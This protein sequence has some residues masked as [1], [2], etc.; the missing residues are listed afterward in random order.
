MVIS[1]EPVGLLEQFEDALPDHNV[2][3]VPAGEPCPPLEDCI[4]RLREFIAH[5]FDHIPGKQISTGQ[6][7]P[8]E[9]ALSLI[10]DSFD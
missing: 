4:L 1:C 9:D 2:L 6:V 7:L 5:V 8:V 10:L 3:A